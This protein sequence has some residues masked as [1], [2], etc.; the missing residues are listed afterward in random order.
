MPSPNVQA[1]ATV[2]AELCASVA[3][4]VENDSAVAAGEIA[5]D[6]DGGDTAGGPD[7]EPDDGADVNVAVTDAT[8]FIVTTQ[9]PL[10]VHA[11]DQPEKSEPEAGVAVS[12]TIVPDANDAEHE[13][14]HEIE[15]PFETDP[16]PVTVTVSANDG[17]AA[18]ATS[19]APMSQC[20]PCGRDVPRSSSVGHAA[21]RPASSAGLVAPG[22]CVSVGPPLFWSEPS[23]AATPCWSPVPVS[24]HVESSARLLPF[25]TRP[26]VLQSSGLFDASSVLIA[27]TCELPYTKTP[28]P[29]PSASFD[30]IVSLTSDVVDAARIPPPF[31]PA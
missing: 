28:A 9:L 18:T 20:G 30:A 17:G 21:S 5:I 22:S 26:G 13:P 12:V 10:P 6:T 19:I 11:P 16:L 14:G 3:V 27:E 23:C 31:V 24:A 8:A 15:P 2:V 7:G 4:S 1:Y 25:E 29:S